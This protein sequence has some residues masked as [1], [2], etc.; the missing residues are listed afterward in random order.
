MDFLR[1]RRR[2]GPPL[3]DHPVP[4]WPRSRMGPSSTWRPRIPLRLPQ[5]L[6]RRLGLEPDEQRLLVL[7]GALIATLLGGYTI[8]KVH[9]DAMFLHEFGA[10]SL[11]YAYIAT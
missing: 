11:P 7:M 2:A 5:S 9:R 10:L 6:A 1:E 4:I 3:P 8:A